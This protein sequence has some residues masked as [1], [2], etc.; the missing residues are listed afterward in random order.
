M[1]A[2]LCG[3]GNRQHQECRPHRRRAVTP[4]EIGAPAVILFRVVFDIL[5]SCE[6]VSADD[7]STDD[8]FPVGKYDRNSLV[9][10][11]A[12]ALNVDIR[13]LRPAT[14]MFDARGNTA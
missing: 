6:Q 13:S 4:C 1:T 9:G 7:V 8:T 2:R 3:A 10:R 12:D 5:E 11:V 14:A